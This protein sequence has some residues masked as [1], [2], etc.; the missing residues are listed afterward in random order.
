[1]T[2]LV[3][4]PLPTFLSCIFNLMCTMRFINIFSTDYAFYIHFYVLFLFCTYARRYAARLL[5][6]LLLKD[7]VAW[8]GGWVGFCKPAQ[9][10]YYV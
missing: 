3:S 10:A 9:V 6:E 4:Q 5:C 7:L 1:M 8:M 2:L